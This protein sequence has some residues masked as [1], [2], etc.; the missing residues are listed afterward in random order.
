MEIP[1]LGNGVDQNNM[2]TI[3]S[4]I[5][6]PGELLLAL[7]FGVKEAYD[8]EQE[9]YLVGSQWLAITNNN[10]IYISLRPLKNTTW[11]RPFASLKGVDE[12]YGVFRGAVILNA[13]DSG[14][15]RFGNLKKDDVRVAKRLIEWGMQGFRQPD[16][17]FSF[18][19]NSTQHERMREMRYSQDE[20]TAIIMEFVDMA[21]GERR[22]FAIHY[23]DFLLTD[24]ASYALEQIA[25]RLPVVPAA[26][27]NLLRETLRHSRRIGIVSSFSDLGDRLRKASSL[28][29]SFVW[30]TSLSKKKSILRSNSG[31]LSDVGL[32]AL[33]R[34][35]IGA[36]IQNEYQDFF[37]YT[38]H[39]ILLVKCRQYG[40]DDAF[41]EIS[42]GRDD[43]W[44][45]Y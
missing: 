43:Y 8:G 6:S 42:E 25:L 12:K 35:V 29:S 14:W 32:T 40:I 11:S 4:E 19:Q 36:Q 41:L 15:L 39:I 16:I 10:I 2:E 17:D 5:L 1:Y 21:P 45:N 27:V 3:A 33:N 20:K 37:E 30:E 34:L 22:E 28:I 26:E 38:R 23:S 13:G 18:S 9:I 31:I 24:E 44:M 7:F